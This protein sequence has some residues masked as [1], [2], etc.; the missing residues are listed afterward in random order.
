MDVEKVGEYVLRNLHHEGVVLSVSHSL[1]IEEVFDIFPVLPCCRSYNPMDPLIGGAAAAAGQLAVTGGRHL[2]K[3]G[4]AKLTSWRDR[5]KGLK[6]LDNLPEAPRE[7][8]VFREDDVTPEL[9]AALSLGGTPGLQLSTI[10]VL[11]SGFLGDKGGEGWLSEMDSPEYQEVE[12]DGRTE[13]RPKLVSLED[14]SL[15]DGKSYQFTML[16]ARSSVADL[17][18]KRDASLSLNGNTS[19]EVLAFIVREGSG[20]S[21]LDDRKGLVVVGEQDGRYYCCE[22]QFGLIELASIDQP[23][24]FG[25]PRVPL[26][27]GSKVFKVC[28][29][30][31]EDYFCFERLC[32]ILSED[33]GYMVKLIGLQKVVKELG[34][35][36]RTQIAGDG[37]PLSSKEH[38]KKVHNNLGKNPTLEMPTDEELRTR[39]EE[40]IASLP[41]RDRDAG[42]VLFPTMQKVISDFRKNIESEAA[43]PGHVGVQPYKEEKSSSLIRSCIVR[44]AG[45]DASFAIFNRFSKHKLN[46]AV[47]PGVTAV[48]FPGLFDMTVA[49]PEGYEVQTTRRVLKPACPFTKDLLESLPILTRLARRLAADYGVL[50]NFAETLSLELSENP[51]VALSPITDKVKEV[52]SPR[53]RPRS[54]LSFGDLLGYLN[55][56]DPENIRGEASVAGILC[57]LGMSLS[58]PPRTEGCEVQDF[59]CFFEVCSEVWG[60]PTFV[61]TP[62]VVDR[63]IDISGLQVFKACM[64]KNLDHGVKKKWRREA[65]F[66]KRWDLPRQFKYELTGVPWDKLDVVQDCRC[67]FAG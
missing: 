61:G 31:L 18:L 58:M 54:A 40:A 41:V 17:Q 49:F 5:S 32:Q 27:S 35:E 56:K 28:P 38:L 64:E 37:I 46:I 20:G 66:L 2:A 48:Y 50:K 43:R 57:Q 59:R 13:R 29:E 11:K 6:L 4:R 23:T 65:F 24:P 14:H 63:A 30:V 15:F 26:G 55:E 19:V 10:A 60:K 9:L 51:A 44:A 39:V 62:L 16:D 3:S 53:G 12:K 1:Y 7:A 42:L 8:F 52:L 33:A 67:R 22:N 47:S 45:V 25:L 36:F 34:K 21:M